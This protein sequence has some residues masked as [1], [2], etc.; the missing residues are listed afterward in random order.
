MRYRH[1]LKYYIPSAE[2]F[3]LTQRMASILKYDKNSNQTGYYVTSLYFDDMF[4]DSYYQKI[5]GVYEREKFRIRI[6]NY[7]SDFIKLE[8][9]KKIASY[10]KKDSERISYEQYQNIVRGNG[11][12]LSEATDDHKSLLNKFLIQCKIKKLSPV[13]IVDY[14]RHVF[15]DSGDLRISFDHDLR[16]S[17]GDNDLFF[18]NPSY[19]RVLSQDLVIMEIKYSTYLPAHIH[20]LLN[21]AKAQYCSI[22]KYVMCLDRLKEVKCFAKF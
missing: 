15:V 9:K 2:A 12:S 10:V 21:S 17:T 20:A 16:V 22:S 3:V 14:L 4:F 5:E 1:E 6:Y 19:L 18:P 11:C 13:V 8:L 7:S